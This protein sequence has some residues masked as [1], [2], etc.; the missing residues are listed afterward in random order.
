MLEHD[1]KVNQ[2]ISSQDFTAEKKHRLLKTALRLRPKIWLLNH[3]WGFVSPQSGLI[4]VHCPPWNLITDTSC[5]PIPSM[6]CHAITDGYLNHVS[7]PCASNLRKR[8]DFEALL[9]SLRVEGDSGSCRRFEALRNSTQFVHFKLAIKSQY[10]PLANAATQAHLDQLPVKP[11]YFF[12]ETV[13][14]DQYG[15]IVTKKGF[16]RIT[17]GTFSVNKSNYSPSND[18]ILTFEEN[19][20]YRS[21]CFLTDHTKFSCPKA[22]CA[23]FDRGGPGSKSC[24]AGK[25]AQSQH[26]NLS[27]VTFTASNQKTRDR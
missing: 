6:S 15:S 12:T 26:A 21:N 4:H 24:Q 2:T 7:L 19:I 17:K 8:K 27:R 20:K 9:D 22:H 25:M 18:I 23:R 3:H 13:S 16:I 5:S 14:P 10:S 11:K 1:N